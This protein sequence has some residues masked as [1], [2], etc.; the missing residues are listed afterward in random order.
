[1]LA[2]LGVQAGGTFALWSSV[3]AVPASTITSGTTGLTVNG[4]STATLTGLDTTKLGPGAAVA[5]TITLANTGTTILTVAASQ[6]VVL[7]DSQGLAAE[8]TVRTVAVPP[9]QCG[10]STTGGVV[11]RIPGFQ[12]SAAPVVITPGSSATVCLV[13]ALDSDAPSSA[14]GGTTTFRVTFTGKQVG[15]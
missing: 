10:P 6:G 7:A 2:V 12:S 5:T 4:Q 13:V 11:G 3:K 14:Q 1:M 15:P 9:A 8:L